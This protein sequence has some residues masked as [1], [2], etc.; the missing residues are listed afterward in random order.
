MK[1]DLEGWKIPKK[2]LRF[3]GEFLFPDFC[4]CPSFDCVGDFLTEKKGVILAG[5]RGDLT[6]GGVRAVHCC[7][8]FV[9]IEF[10]V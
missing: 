5:S 3:L 1:K 7:H 6:H 10:R 4:C 8:E 2:S 9:S